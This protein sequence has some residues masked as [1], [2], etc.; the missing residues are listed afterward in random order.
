MTSVSA[1]EYASFTLEEYASSHLQQMIK[2]AACQEQAQADFTFC[3]HFTIS[4]ATH[5]LNLIMSK[6]LLILCILIEYN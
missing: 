1:V 5:F 6:N 2:T 3:R 4:Q